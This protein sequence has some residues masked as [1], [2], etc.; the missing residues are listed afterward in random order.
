MGM[1][2]SSHFIALEY[3]SDDNCKKSLEEDENND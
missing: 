2:H 1:P 3:Q